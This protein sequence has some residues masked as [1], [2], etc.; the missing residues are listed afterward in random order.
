MNAARVSGEGHAFHGST[1]GA[2]FPGQ[3]SEKAGMGEAFARR[4]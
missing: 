1:F 4:P 3:L 2:L